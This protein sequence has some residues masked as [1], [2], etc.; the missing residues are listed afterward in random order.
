MSDTPKGIVVRARPSGW[1][2]PLG[3]LAFCADCRRAFSCSE[4]A[5]PVCAAENGIFRLWS[6]EHGI[7]GEKLREALE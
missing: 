6:P 3:E 1:S 2:V 5:C 7:G 4:P